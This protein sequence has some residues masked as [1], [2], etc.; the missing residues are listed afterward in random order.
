MCMLSERYKRPSTSRL[1][2]E[3]EP[4][5]AASIMKEDEIKAEGSTPV[6]VDNMTDNSFDLDF[7]AL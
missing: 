3:F 4:F 6:V 7:G 1:T 2:I 5:L